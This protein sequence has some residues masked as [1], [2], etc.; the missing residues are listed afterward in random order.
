MLFNDSI[1]KLTQLLNLFVHVNHYCD[2][3]QVIYLFV[4]I[5]SVIVQWTCISIFLCTLQDTVYRV[6]FTP[7]F[8]FR[9]FGP[10]CQRAN[11]SLSKFHCL[12]LSIFKHKLCLGEFKTGWNCLQVKKG[13]NNLI[14]FY[15]ISMLLEPRGCN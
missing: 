2:M 7:V 13:E 11:S 1:P 6:I 5:E 9:P 4:V 15:W 3:H 14:Q 10:Y 8:Y 12:K